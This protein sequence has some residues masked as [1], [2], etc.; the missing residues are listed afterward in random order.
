MMVP[1]FFV[2]NP[3]LV[4]H[5]TTWE[6]MGSM[7]LAILGILLLASGFEGYTFLLRKIS[8]PV[9]AIFMLNGVLLFF[10]FMAVRLIGVI[11]IGVGLLLHLLLKRNIGSGG[12]IVSNQ[13]T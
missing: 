9:R 1:F 8:I 7:S 11:G 2:Y 13:D 6:I 4:A 5:G 12:E 3:S 10:P